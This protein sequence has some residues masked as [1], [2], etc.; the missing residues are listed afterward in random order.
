MICR[1]EIDGYKMDYSEYVYGHFFVS[2]KMLSNFDQAYNT[3]QK[4][5]KT[6]DISI[7]PV[8]DFEDALNKVNKIFDLPV[9]YYDVAGGLM[10]DFVPVKTKGLVDKFEVRYQ[11]NK[12]E[13]FF[14]QN[15]TNGSQ[16]ANIPLKEYGIT[17]ITP[18]YKDKK[19]LDCSIFSLEDWQSTYKKAML[20]MELIKSDKS[21][22]NLCESK[23][24]GSAMLRYMRVYGIDDKLLSNVKVL[25]S[26]IMEQDFS[27]AVERCSII[28]QKHMGMPEYNGYRS[29]RIQETFSGITILLD[30]YKLLQDTTYLEFAINALQS[31]LKNYMQED[32]EIRKMESC[33][34]FEYVDYTTVTCLILPVID[35]ANTLKGLCDSRYIGFENSAKLIASHIINRGLDFPTEGGTSDLVEQEMED[36]S[37]SCSALTVAYAYRFLN[38][39]Q[40][41]LDTADFILGYHDAWTISTPT[42]CMFRSTLRW[43]ETIWE[44]GAHGPSISGGHPW[45]IWRAEALFHY[46]VAAMDT[47]RLVDSYNAFF[48]NLSK[49]QQDGTSFA[50]YFADYF[51]SGGNVTNS[52]EVPFE[53]IKGLPKTSDNGITPYVWTRLYETWFRCCALVCV[54]EQITALNGEL[55]TKQGFASLEIKSPI[56]EFVY[57]D[58]YKGILVIKTDKT[59]TILSKS[60]ITVIEGANPWQVKNGISIIPI[61]GKITI[62]I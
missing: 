45:T 6:I 43:W 47:E 34:N 57:I 33:Y 26:E 19:G 39:K 27:K 61:D 42:A 51:A 20:K 48:S 16:V 22:C 28:T 18:Y 2:L 10:N 49:I 44:G 60:K 54:D 7:Q 55:S 29:L 30:A 52:S 14:P 24:W 3:P 58:G 8:A 41:Y 38:E 15:K 5:K 12:I 25:L 17:T 4:S 31:M 59:I 50:V 35:M 62:K 11:S 53:Y 9:A 37:I 56:K 32:G 21:D 36:G 13:A 46:A 40:E 1:N 23:M